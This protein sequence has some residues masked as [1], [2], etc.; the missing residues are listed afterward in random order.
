MTKTDAPADGISALI[1]VQMVS[2]A[3]CNGVS[4]PMIRQCPVNEAGCNWETY[5]W[6]GDDL[7]VEGC[8]IAMRGTIE[9]LQAHYQL[10]PSEASDKRAPAS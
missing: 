7:A 1:A 5:D 9:V 10:A 6:R 2:F 3:E 8:Q 4:A